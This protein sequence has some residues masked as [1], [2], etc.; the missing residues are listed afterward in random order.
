MRALSHLWRRLARIDPR[1]LDGL[2]A[3]GLATAAAVQFLQH[4]PLVP[5][6]FLPVLG[7]ALP[8][9]WRRRWPIAMIA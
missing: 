7:T 1:L 9:A 4:E 6:R 8:L 3:I 2:L 5:Q